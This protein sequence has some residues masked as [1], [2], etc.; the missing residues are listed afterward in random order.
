MF[1][2]RFAVAVDNVLSE[3]GIS[4]VDN[5]PAIKKI[6][7]HIN[8]DNIMDLITKYFERI[9]VPETMS[10]KIATNAYNKMIIIGEDSLIKYLQDF[11]MYV[12]SCIYMTSDPERVAQVKIEYENIATE[13]EKTAKTLFV[14]E[15]S[16]KLYANIIKYIGQQY[17]DVSEAFCSAS[18]YYE[19]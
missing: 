12:K 3:G 19:L 7:R 15:D 8:A 18:I 6:I 1:N 14:S 16:P 2:T 5:M 11:S 4:I 9:G 13:K 17:P 10:D